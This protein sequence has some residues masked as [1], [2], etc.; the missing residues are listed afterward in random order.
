MNLIPRP[1]VEAV[2]AHDVSHDAATAP[3][4]FTVGSTLR[5]VL[6][7]T[8]TG[9]AG[10]VAVFM[11]EFLTLLYISRLGDTELTAAVGYASQITFL[12]ISTNI[13]LT[14]ALGALVSRALGARDRAKARRIAASGVTL[15]ALIA[16]ALSF[17]AMPFTHAILAAIGARGEALEIGAV[18]L[19][20]IL[21][22][23]LL[24]GLGMAF[25]AVLRGV[26]DA[27]RAMYV[28]LG[29]AI[30]TAVPR[31][32]LHL[33]DAPRRRRRRHRGAHLARRPGG[34]GLAR[35]RARARSRR[36]PEPRRAARR[37]RAA[38]GDRGAGR[39]HQHRL[40]DRQHLRDADLLELRGCGRR[41]LRDHGS[42][43]AGRL[44]CAVRA[45]GRRRADHGPELRGEGLRPRPRL[46]STIAT[47]SPAAYVVLVGGGAVAR[48][49]GDRLAVC[50]QRRDGRAAHLLLP[51]R[52]PAV[53]FFSVASLSQMPRYNNLGWPFLSTAINWGPRDAGDDPRSSPMARHGMGQRAATSGWSSA[54]ALFGVVAVVGSYRLV[55][56]ITQNAG[57]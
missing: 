38:G 44:R 52:R 26:G 49:A 43:D 22:G 5:H 51:C 17:A 6:V 3:G 13:G 28:T 1:P 56:R 29:G 10:L 19:R 42:R 47:A 24:L 41:S 11:V 14:I 37:R 55:G 34:D 50:R 53:V 45:V 35:R 46:C 48:G 8:T 15:M 16:G 2:Q 23:T 18:Y 40:A 7:M 20:I 25:S 36:P 27:R 12:L 21:P 32:D 30:V 31:S 57:A 9:A 39:A 54:P 33:R 4:A